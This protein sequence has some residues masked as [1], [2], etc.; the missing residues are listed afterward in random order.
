M[1]NES[2]QAARF[3]RHEQGKLPEAF[4]GDQPGTTFRVCRYYQVLVL[5]DYCSTMSGGPWTFAYA[6]SG[7]S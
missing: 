6:A 3:G 4:R 7:K 1:T 5:D 2:L